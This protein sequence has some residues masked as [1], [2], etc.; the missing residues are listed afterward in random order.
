ME[1]GIPA[2]PSACTDRAQL[3]ASQIRPQ[4]LVEAAESF[5]YAAWQNAVPLLR[6]M[7]IDNSNGPE[8]SSLIVELTAKP[9]FSRP[10]QWTVDRVP[11]TSLYCA[12]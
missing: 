2:S 9:A 7:V 11:K 4:L 3:A 8:L 6:S 10:K 12:S 5:N 1:N